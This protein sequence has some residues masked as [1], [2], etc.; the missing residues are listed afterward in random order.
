MTRTTRNDAPATES[1]ADIV[2]GY[3]AAFNA[4]DADALNA[5]FTPDAIF[6]NIHGGMVRGA[7]DLHRVQQAVFGPGGQLRGTHV[8]YT[9]ASELRLTTDVAIVHARQQLTDADGAPAPVGAQSV[10]TFVLTRTPAGWR[11]RAGQN[12]AVI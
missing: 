8:R 2:A 5:L 11:I 9:V 10:V 3:E 12:T 7:A 4:Y 1:P 6:V